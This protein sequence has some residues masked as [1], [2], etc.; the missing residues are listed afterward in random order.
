MHS[1]DFAASL[2]HTRR[3]L[4]ITITNSHQKP[5]QVKFAPLFISYLAK[6]GVCY[7]PLIYVLPSKLAI[8][9]VLYSLVG[10]FYGARC[11]S[12]SFFFINVGSGIHC[13]DGKKAN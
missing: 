1:V 13:P 12:G 6:L 5:F 8:G 10:E 9:V 3:T 7:L 11:Q 4:S 2:V